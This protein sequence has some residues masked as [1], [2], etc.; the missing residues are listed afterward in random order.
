MRDGLLAVWLHPTSADPGTMT[1]VAMDMTEVPDLHVRLVASTGDTITVQV[2]DGRAPV[3]HELMYVQS[4]GAYELARV[5]RWGEER[6]LL[7][8]RAWPNRS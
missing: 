8:M 2:V 1:R 6:V 3:G 7:A 5:E 4:R